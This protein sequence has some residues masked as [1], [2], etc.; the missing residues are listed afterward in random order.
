MSQRLL[1]ILFCVA[2]LVSL[3][4]ISA[5]AASTPTPTLLPGPVTVPP[6]I[7]ARA[8]AWLEQH[9]PAETT[10]YTV[11]HIT[12][13]P[14]LIYVS[15]VALRPEASA[16]FSIE[17]E[18]IWWD[19]PLVLYPDGSAEW[20]VLPGETPQ[21][22]LNRL[23]FLAASI[24]PAWNLWREQ[25][26]PG[27]GSMLQFPFTGRG[28]FGPLGV[29]G[30]DEFGFIGGYAVDWV[31]GND[32]GGNVMPATI[33]ASAD[34]TVVGVCQD[35]NSTAITVN[36]GITND[37][38]VYAHLNLSANYEIGDSIFK[39]GPLGTLKYGTY[40]E[41]GG[42]GCECG[43]AS[44]A[45]NHYHVHWMFDPEDGF[46]QVGKWVLKLGEG[47][48]V[49][50]AQKVCINGWMDS[51]N[52]GSTGTDDAAINTLGGDHI[53]D[54]I[55]VG[56]YQFM[57][58]TVGLFSVREMGTG[59]SKLLTMTVNVIVFSVR[60]LN[61]LAFGAYSLAAW[62]VVIGLVMILEGARWLVAIWRT[63]MKLIPFVS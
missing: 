63:I 6:E 38:F 33:V 8:L 51:A 21:A 18:A 24:L 12:Y 49:S 40:C 42:S 13:K 35:D 44:Q 27:G 39:G 60:I 57:D 50:G 54:G 31:G 15:L 43:Y 46:F 3:T 19:R 23:G 58:A 16:D 34:G 47:C 52:A 53:W 11:T 55:L 5:Q 32:L 14:D 30:A 26:A 20:M 28:M 4:P 9:P 59:G 2:L 48:W 22:R 41:G 56:L 25:A 29:H 61:L 62:L 37:K 10:L 1:S 17:T 45:A 7:A 36:N